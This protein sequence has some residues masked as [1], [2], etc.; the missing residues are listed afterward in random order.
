MNMHSWILAARP[1]TLPAAIIPVFVGSGL[2]YWAGGFSLWPAIIC[3]LFALTIQI[4]TNFANDYYDWKQG[5]D[6]EDRIGPT[7]A[8]AS[9]LIRPATMKVAAFT[10]LALAFLI[11]LSLVYWGGL[12]LI[13]IG[14]ISV[15]SAVAYTAQP[16]ALGYRGLGDLFVIIF[17]GFVAVGFTTYT[18]VGAFPAIVWPTGL[19]IGL[20]ANNLLIVNNYRDHESDAAAGKRTLIVRLG[21]G[22][23]EAMVLL[24]I[25]VAAA[26]CIGIALIGEHW[27]VLIALPGLFPVF[28]VWQK[29][30]RALRREGFGPLLQKCA[31]GLIVF[32]TLL[33]LALFLSGTGSS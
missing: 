28:S 13:A 26:L 17:F 3:A 12:W 5:A 30:P 7:R 16:I 2:A 29:L 25:F 20:L 9:G 18:Q 24:S 21:P 6:T 8:V 31:T 15:L 10:T 33:T 11:G 19:A 14:V 4:G 1:R 23:G 27:L 22:F 32:G